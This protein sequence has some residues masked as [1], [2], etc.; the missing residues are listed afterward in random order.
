MINIRKIYKNFGPLEVLVFV[1]VLYVVVMLMWTAATRNGVL[2]KVNNIKSNHK[3]VVEFLNIEINECSQ[4]LQKKTSW[5][6]DCNSTWTS[7]AIVEHIL[8]NVKL[9]NPYF[10]TKPLIQSSSDPRIDAEGKAGQSTNKGVI[11][12]S[13]NDFN[14]E[15][16]SEWIVGTCVKSP[17]VA[18]GNNEL[19]SIYR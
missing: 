7:S 10:L 16:G 3:N 5:G 2:N 19:V 4:N 15:A 1:S 13:L 11:F 8:N 14:S 12:V 17:C 18:A 9:K 6:E